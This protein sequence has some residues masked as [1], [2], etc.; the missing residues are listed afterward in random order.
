MELETIKEASII[1]R[2]VL[3]ASAALDFNQRSV[4]NP[5][6]L[7]GPL[8]SGKSNA[9]WPG[10]VC[11]FSGNDVLVRV[12]CMNW[13]PSFIRG[14]V[15]GP[16][17]TRICPDAVVLD[18]ERKKLTTASHLNCRDSPIIPCLI[19][20][21]IYQQLSVDICSWPPPFVAI[22]D[23]I[24]WRRRLCGCGMW[25]LNISFTNLSDIVRLC[26]LGVLYF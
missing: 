4:G 25:T 23:R 14:A 24:C 9:K 3:Q 20:I 17:S 12:K 18:P 21:E 22:S 5:A 1:S 6:C 26:I 15:F 13:S 16:E 19:I 11:Y 7:Q 8:V 2:E 10:V